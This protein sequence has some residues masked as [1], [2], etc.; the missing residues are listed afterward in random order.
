MSISERYWPEQS[1][2]F[3]AL[4][5][6]LELPLAPLLVTGQQCPISVAV[7]RS[8][9]KT[10]EE[11]WSGPGSKPNI[12]DELKALLTEIQEGG[13]VSD[14]EI[15][16]LIVSLAQQVNSSSLPGSGLCIVVDE[17]GKFLEW[18][19]TQGQEGGDIYLLQ[20]LAEAS[21]RAD[22]APILFITT[23]HQSLDAYA[24][25]L[26]RSTQVEWSKISGR[27]ETIPFLETPRHL[28]KLLSGALNA[29][30]DLKDSPVYERLRA[31]TNRLVEDN[32]RLGDFDASEL[33]G[34]FPL[35]PITA[36]CLGPLFRTRLGQNERS[37]FAFLSSHEPYGFQDYLHEEGEELE[38]AYKLDSLYDYVLTNTGV[39]VLSDS[40]D[41]TWAAAEQALSRL[42]G[43][44][45]KLDHDLIKHITI[46]SHVG[47]NVGLRANLQT[48][49]LSTGAGADE[50]E[51]S[52]ERLESRSAVVF[53][54]FKQA[55]HI[56]DGSDLNI[57]ELLRE[58]RR[59]VKA[60]GQL[61]KRL[62]KLLSPY[63]VVASRHYHQTGT[64]RHLIP[65]YVG[66]PT[67]VK[68]WPT[69]KDGDGDILYVVPDRIEELDDAESLI[70][71][72]S[73][74]D[75][76]EERPRIVALPREAEALVGRILDYFSI[77]D[78]LENTPEL[79]NDPVARRELNERRLTA[80]DRL[81]DAVATSFTSP[82]AELDWYWRG[83]KLESERRPSAY[84]SRV[85][86]RVYHAAPTIENEL[87]NRSSV[88]SYTS[89]ARRELMELMME[90]EAEERLGL[91]GFPAEVSLYRSVLERGG[92]HHQQE[93]GTWVFVRPDEESTYYE[94]WQYLDELL[95]EDAGTRLDFEHLIEKLTEPPYGIR[96][97]VAPILLLAYYLS[98]RGELFLYEDNSFVPAPG[99]DMA[100][101][102]VNRPSTFE[103]Q[104]VGTS[105]EVKQVLSSLG[106]KFGMDES[107]TFFRLVRYVV[108]QVARL[109]PYASKT[110]DIG[111][112]PRQVRSVVKGARDP[113][114]LLLVSLPEA[115]GLQPV[116]SRQLELAPLEPRI[117]DEPTGAKFAERLGDAIDE[118]NALDEQ[119]LD[120]IDA[121]VRRMFGGG[122]DDSNF[123]RDLAERAQSVEASSSIPMRIRNLVSVLASSPGSDKSG[124]RSHLQGIGTA[125]LGKPPLN[126]TDEDVRQFE[127][128][129]VEASRKFLA[130][131]ELL[132][133]SGQANRN[134]HLL[135]VSVL[136]SK[137]NERHGI[138]TTSLE[139]E[140]VSA[141]Q[142][143]VM[144]LAREHELEGED[145][146]F[147]VISSMMEFLDTESKQEVS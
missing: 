97:G 82:N 115:V 130:T 133:E 72:T 112:N 60:E 146:A 11:F 41:R 116:T 5:D 92:L 119:L 124:I 89:G 144:D 62:Q 3:E 36:L 105:E 84:A 7:L 35:H 78:A 18:A 108:Q 100:A 13:Q 77:E 135:R 114:K 117:M 111:E 9:V 123:Y 26:P 63:P 125:I 15:V 122:S 44:A 103:L 27:F 56:W 19:A 10:A 43:D 32:E 128:R 131:E 48:L 139:D 20:L 90:H 142:E 143:K 64:L 17:M 102:L 45:P 14:S 121:T 87:I 98:R 107:A 21:A 46:L 120:Y 65:R 37:L 127:Y 12:I 23:L 8:A 2:E 33:Y 55:Y 73:E 74:H 40:G 39:R 66:V 88:S 109:S 104:H 126:W 69:G 140:R 79:S 95:N 29:K 96:S 118:L 86:D 4:T 141:F 59:K 34:C 76:G 101:R 31:E 81:A 138:S 93:D 38:Q 80:K 58:R 94:T 42:P 145:V 132:L 61:G 24:K 6:Q 50:I 28:I 75:E 51:Q 30:E 83:E 106:D 16:E 57:P 137:G 134:G 25:G 22:D 47:V 67:N 85:F 99:A 91:D 49:E 113:V 52:L 54:E 147:A 71:A 136:D 53:R 129:A 1:T 110:Q 70:T 68:K